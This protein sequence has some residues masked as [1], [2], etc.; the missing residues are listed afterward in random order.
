MRDVCLEKRTT[1]AH[2]ELACLGV[3]VD[4]QCFVDILQNSR[5]YQGTTCSSI[6]GPTVMS[7]KLDLHI[8][9]SGF[10]C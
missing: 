8:A 2:D 9:G 1:G 3:E 4:L 10:G 5:V 7:A 6:I